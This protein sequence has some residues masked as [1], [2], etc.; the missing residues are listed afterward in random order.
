MPGQIT[1]M[2]CTS[3]FWLPVSASAATAAL[4][5]RAETPMRNPPVTSLIKAQRPV[6]SSASSQRASCCGS[7]A[8]P[9]VASVSTTRVSVRLSSSSPAKRGGGRR[10]INRPHQR[11]GLGEVADIIVRKFEQYRI[12]ALRNQRADETCFGMWEAECAGERRQRPAALGIACRAKIVDHQPQLIVAARLV[13]EA[14]EQLGEAVHE[15]SLP[16]PGVLLGKR[17]SLVFAFRPPW[18]S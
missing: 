1:S 12:G 8:L 14:V 16:R 13:S 5:R 6:S 2:S 15:P 17:S 11:D 7:C 10:S 9:S 3:T 4:A 18:P